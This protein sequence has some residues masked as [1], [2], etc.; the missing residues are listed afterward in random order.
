MLSV[1]GFRCRRR[2]DERGVIQSP[3]FLFSRD[4]KSSYRRKTHRLRNTLSETSGT[5]TRSDLRVILARYTIHTFPYRNGNAYSVFPETRDFAP[6]TFTGWPLGEEETA[7]EWLGERDRNVTPELSAAF[8]AASPWSRQKFTTTLVSSIGGIIYEQ[9][10]SARSDDRKFW[11][12]IRSF[13]YACLMLYI[14]VYT[15]ASCFE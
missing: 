2:S 8:R 14:I 13:V 4:I 1:F 6:L 15:C 11:F 3:R 5:D 12:C 9:M 10:R 7:R